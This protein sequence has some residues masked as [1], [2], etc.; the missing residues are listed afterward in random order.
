MR[1]WNELEES[2]RDKLFTLVTT[3]DGKGSADY[4]KG[5]LDGIDMVIDKLKED[6]E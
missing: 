4:K 3:W 1:A 2:M 6:N 5:V